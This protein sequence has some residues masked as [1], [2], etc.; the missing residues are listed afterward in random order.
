MNGA[1]FASLL[2]VVMLVTAAAC[3][4]P[5]QRSD[6]DW[7]VEDPWSCAVAPYDT[8]KEFALSPDGHRISFLGNKAGKWEFVVSSGWKWKVN[9][10][11]RIDSGPDRDTGRSLTL[12]P[13]GGRVA[14]VYNRVSMWR[15]TGPRRSED[16]NDTNGQWFVDIDH[17]IFGGFDREFKPVVHFSP[18]GRK[19]GFPY[20]KL[21]QYYV[22]V[23]DTTFGPYDRADMAITKDGGI[24]LGY[25]RQHRAYIE[26]IYHPDHD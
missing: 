10:N 3:R 22:Q 8:I 9:D 15:A 20:R 1:R 21:G 24:V 19:F 12:S 26:T 17:H 13:D 4:K 18:D 6:H 16:G 11:A 7:A 5:R 25:I 23:V 2:A 14:I